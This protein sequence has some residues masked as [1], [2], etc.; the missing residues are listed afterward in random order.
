[1][2]EK[3]SIIPTIIIVFVCLAVG[4]ATGWF[5]GSQG[6]GGKEQPVKPTADSSSKLSDQQEAQ[7]KA[8]I[9]LAIVAHAD[10]L[11]AEVYTSLKAGN[12]D[13]EALTTLQRVAMANRASNRQRPERTPEDHDK[14]WDVQV[15]D[16]MVRGPENAVVTIVKFSE[17]QCPACSK[18]YASLEHIMEQY[19]GKIRLVFKSKILQ[20]HTEAP[21]AH[22]AALAAGEQDKFWEFYDKIYQA[23]NGPDRRDA[24]KRE[25]LLKYA[26]EL[27][28]DMAR[29][30]K[31]MDS[32]K[33]AD[34]LAKEAREGDA[35]KIRATPTIFI[36]GH[37]YTGLPRNL[38]EIV[39]KYI[40]Q[41]QDK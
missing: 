29:F 13:S 11:A 23:R 24:L 35:L 5:I 14:V 34:F 19:P 18:A 4:L 22:N 25:N 16:S 32:D 41:P 40:G 3:G 37:R 26:Q 39:E 27:G 33:F 21:L 6:L 2:N 36:N 15:N 9:S 31:D 10:E 7:V 17:F 12:V 8:A 28:L 20:R 38:K 1:M 30:E